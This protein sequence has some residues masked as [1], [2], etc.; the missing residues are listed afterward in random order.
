[1]RQTAGFMRNL[2][3]IVVPAIAVAAIGLAVLVLQYMRDT[4]RVEDIREA[5]AL[6]AADEMRDAVREAGAGDEER[7]RV[8]AAMLAAR[9]DFF[10]A[11]PSAAFAWTAKKGLVWRQGLDESLVEKLSPRRYWKDWYP[12]GKRVVRRAVEPMEKGGATAYLLWGR[13]G[14]CLYGLVF[15]EFPVAADSWTWLWLAGIG[16][17]VAL[18]AFLVYA[19]VRLWRAA[20]N[21][22]RDDE[23]KTRFVSDVSHE[24]KTP[25][26]AMGLWADMLAGGR[27]ADEGRRRHALDVIVEE[28]GRMLRL[29]DTLLDFT[30]LEQ[31]RRKYCLE[32]VDVGE[33][34]N[35]VVELLRGDFGDDGVSI[36]APSG[37]IAFADRDAVKGIFV[38]LLGNA[39]KYAVAGGTVEVAVI[40][41]DGG[42]RATVSDR[43]PGIAPQ[44]REKVF[45][46]FYRSEDGAARAKG[47]F[48][49][50][51]PISRRLARDMG[52][53][54][55]A[56]SR[57]GGGSVFV[58]RLNRFGC[59]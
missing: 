35:E 13:V 34:A 12:E 58:L 3:H 1:M 44:A 59:R 9:P 39:A 11:R 8:L 4:S 52:G 18:A 27:L 33:V 41:E 5:R 28:K 32:A 6:N 56:E 24:L 26:A 10:A 47:G 20:E 54:L 42:V 55:T 16:F 19:A 31:G 45:E 30:R 15:D 21:A 37:C 43:G 57:P 23:L 25:L 51:L 36:D 17:I 22:R 7:R 49:L 53:E 14:S 48:G 38:N 46:R 2:F 50:G 29:V 40:C